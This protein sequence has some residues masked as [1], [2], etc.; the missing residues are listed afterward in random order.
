MAEGANRRPDRRSARKREAILIAAVDLFLTNG[1]E[2]TSVDA[3]ALAAGVGKQT[4]YSHFAGKETLFLA[5]VESA[6]AAPAQTKGKLDPDPT[7]PSDGL[8]ALGAAVLGVVLDPT[9]AAL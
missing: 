6:R 2:R 5:A 1:Y 8:H 4:V 9:V 7:R 3:V